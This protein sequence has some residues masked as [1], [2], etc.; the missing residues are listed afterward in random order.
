MPIE[1]LCVCCA[2]FHIHYIHTFLQTHLF[3]I[4]FYANAAIDKYSPKHTRPLLLLLF[5]VELFLWLVV[6]LDLRERK[7]QL[8]LNKCS[9]S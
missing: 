2:L 3:C 8:N 1:H 6:D 9:A 4:F 7:F 5:L